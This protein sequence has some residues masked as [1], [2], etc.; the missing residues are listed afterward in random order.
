MSKAN[1]L[2][3]ALLDHLFGRT[4]YTAPA[5]LYISLHTGDPGET[6]ANNEVTGNNYSR[7]A[8]TNS[9]GNFGSAS[10]GSK[11][12]AAEIQFAVPSGSWGTVTHFAIW[13][14]ASA[15]NCLYYGALTSAMAMGLNNDIKI[16]IGAL[17]IS[18]D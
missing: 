14:A 12:N 6:G 18:E 9:T 17:T 15:G 3:N 1:Y 5:T 11:T 4:T 10:G 13:D 8:V 2:E 16:A 7:A